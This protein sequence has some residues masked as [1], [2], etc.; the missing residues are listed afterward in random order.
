MN[1]RVKHYAGGMFDKFDSLEFA[2]FPCSSGLSIRGFFAG[3]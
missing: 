3:G 1:F 2:I